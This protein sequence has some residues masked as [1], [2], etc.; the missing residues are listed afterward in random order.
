[1]LAL[2]VACARAPVLPAETAR[3]PERV[4][5]TG[6]PFYPQSAYQC[7]PAALATMLSQRG[8]DTS[9]GLL[10][11]QVYLPGRKGS[12]QVEMV[13]AARR[14]GMLVYPLAPRLE[15][16]LA[17]VSA[18]NPV[19]VLQNLALDWWPS[20]HFAVVVGYDRREQQLIL[21]S[22]TT[23]R[24]TIDFAT[25][26]R[27]WAKGGRWAVL[28]LPANRLPA[29]AQAQPWLKAASDLEETGQGDAAQ[30]A[31][32]TAVTRWPEASVGWFALANSRHAQGNR[33]GA[34]E[35]LR[36]SLRRDPR[37][38]AGWFNL[39]EVLAERGCPA[40]ASQARSCARQL[41]PNDARFATELPPARGGGAS[42]APVPACPSS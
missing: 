22:G 31:Y 1:M 9:P 24:L 12:L 23:R 42:C 33:L 7:G 11:D 26:D 5:L 28:T 14:H 18:G 30:Q 21:R 13:A 15:S 32:R 8:L 17:E 34:E 37:L 36:E 27:T 40:V 2:L 20:W 29:T 41:A 35:A 3:L 25:F 10:K 6:V 38:A 4:E 19:L 16:V 39:S